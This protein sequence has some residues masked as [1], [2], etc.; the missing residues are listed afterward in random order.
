MLSRTATIP[1]LCTH[2][3]MRFAY[4]EIFFPLDLHLFSVFGYAESIEASWKPLSG[5]D[6]CCVAGY[7]AGKAFMFLKPEWGLVFGTQ[8]Q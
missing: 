5:L 8:A 3:P 1:L 7:L 2:F 4:A 6:S